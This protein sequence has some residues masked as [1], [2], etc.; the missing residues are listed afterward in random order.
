MPTGARAFR[1]DELQPEAALAL[2]F[3]LTE[4]ISLSSN[5][6]YTRASDE[7]EGFN[8]FFGSLALGLSLTERVGAYIE[9]YGFTR[10]D[11]TTR[12]SARFANGGFTFLVNND[13]QLD[14]RA[15][16]GLGNNVSGPDYFFGFGFARRF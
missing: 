11:A 2:S 15:G 1:E 16:V 13:F 12:D 14:A 10:V 3:D 9:V 6:G 7:D 8:Q 4:R 5:I